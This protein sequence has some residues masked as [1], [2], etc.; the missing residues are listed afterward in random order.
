MH[1]KFKELRIQGNLEDRSK[2]TSNFWGEGVWHFMTLPYKRKSFFYENLVKDWDLLNRGVSRNLLR[3]VLNLF[4]S[5]L[6]IWWFFLGDFTFFLLQTPKTPP[7]H[8]P[9]SKNHLFCV[10]SF[11]NDSLRLRNAQELVFKFI[12]WSFRRTSS[13]FSS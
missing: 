6:E 12:F 13:I 1:P 3:R 7:E 11:T 10:T 9:G 8:A 5:K 2:L 4:C